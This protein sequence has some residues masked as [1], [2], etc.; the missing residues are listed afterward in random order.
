MV[1]KEMLP[2]VTWGLARRSR[3]ITSQNPRELLVHAC[4]VTEAVT[5]LMND[6]ETV[7][8]KI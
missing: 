7:P 4:S 5:E 1:I 3:R 6:D 2:S 8:M